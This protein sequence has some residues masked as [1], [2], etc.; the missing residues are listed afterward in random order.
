VGARAEIE[1][2]VFIDDPAV[3]LAMLRESSGK[4][5][6]LD[7]LLPRLVLD[8][9][10]CLLFSQMTRML[11]ILEDYL[12][13]T[14]VSYVRIDGSDEAERPPGRRSS[15]STRTRR[16]AL[17]LL[18]TRAGGLGINLTGADTVIIYDSRLEP[19]GRPAGA[20]SR[21]PHRPEARPSPC[22]G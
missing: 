4:F 3:Y 11:D 14:H 8:G 21:A 18:S 15:R 13:L 6:L 16:S 1:P 5:Q 9:H 19:A 22:T 20:G 12:S 10:K 2:S 17:F 7:K